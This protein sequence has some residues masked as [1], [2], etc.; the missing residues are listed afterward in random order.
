[1]SQD[2]DPYYTWFGIRPEQQPA[3]YYR[4]LGVEKYE[5]NPTIIEN[6]AEARM[7]LVQSFRSGEHSTTSQKILNEISQ[8]KIGLLNDQKRK[9][10]DAQLLALE[11]KYDEEDGEYEEEYEEASEFSTF[12]EPAEAVGNSYVKKQQQQ[13]KTNLIFAGVGVGALILIGLLF[14]FVSGD[15]P[16]GPDDQTRVAQN[17]VAEANTEA[18]VTAHANITRSTPSNTKPVTKN[19][20]PASDPADFGFSNVLAEPATSASPKVTK[21]RKENNRTTWIPD[22]LPS[23]ENIA[24]DK[25][26]T[27]SNFS[28][29]RPPI[30]ATDGNIQTRWTTNGLK[31]LA[32]LQVDLTQPQMITGFRSFWIQKDYAYR[33]YIE[34]SNNEE[35]WTVLV[36]QRSHTVKEQI[37]TDEIKP[38]EFR[39]IRIHNTNAKKGHW[40]CLWEFEIFSGE[41]PPL[42]KRED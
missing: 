12:S 5:D 26:T 21:P 22:Y 17:T 4:L 34:G 15:E 18:N 16:D 9:E 37:N 28:K 25:T 7:M 41:I 40:S 35:N 10:Y 20:K 30:A 36:D 39:Y 31:E 2:F 3:D 42:V 32:W 19:N 23:K 1:M 27:A 24:L 38:V 29:D 33:Y 14:M 11:E 13:Q 6:A 8:A